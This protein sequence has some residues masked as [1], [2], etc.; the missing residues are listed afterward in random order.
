MKDKWPLFCMSISASNNRGFSSNRPA[1]CRAVDENAAWE[2]GIKHA[3]ECFPAREGYS[4]W[5][6]SVLLIPEDF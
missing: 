4:E 3:K 5:Q 2:Y 6:A 1:Y